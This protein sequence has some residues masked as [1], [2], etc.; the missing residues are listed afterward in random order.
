MI[1]L[2]CSSGRARAE[3]LSAASRSVVHEAPG[4]SNSVARKRGGNGHQ[5]TRREASAG[6]I[7]VIPDQ[8]DVAPPPGAWTLV[9]FVV[10]EGRR[11]ARVIVASSR[12]PPRSA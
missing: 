7:A 2:V 12:A 8:I 1:A 10:R 4:P 6:S 5:V 9:Q 11:D 3:L